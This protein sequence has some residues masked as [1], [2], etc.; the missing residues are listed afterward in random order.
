MAFRKLEAGGYVKEVRVVTLGLPHTSESK[1]DWFGHLIT[2]RF[3]KFLSISRDRGGRT[4]CLA[5][6]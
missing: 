3:V 1:T 4:E 2:V 5:Y 6:L